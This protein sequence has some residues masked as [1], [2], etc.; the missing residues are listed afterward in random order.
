[1]REAQKFVRS[2]LDKKWIPAFIT[3]PEFL[4]R[5]SALAPGA[6][7]PKMAIDPTHPLLVSCVWGVGVGVY[8]C[9]CWCVWVGVGVVGVG[10]SGW[11]CG[12][13]WVSV[14]GCVRVFIEYVC[15]CVHVRTYV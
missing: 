13:G 5:N 15:V 2:R 3:Q 1:M 12:C 4:A 6:D 14:C 10:V 11:V 8:G 7:G 9:G